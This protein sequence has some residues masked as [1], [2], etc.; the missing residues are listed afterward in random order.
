[1]I[2]VDTDVILDVML[3]RVPHVEASG[4]LLSL[5]EHRGH[6]AFVA[7]HTLS[8]IYYLVAPSRGGEGVREFLAELTRFVVV[9]PADGDALRFAAAL[10]MT[11]FE[12]ALQVGAARGCGA[13]VIATRNVRDYRGSPI[14]ART[15]RDLLEELG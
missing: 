4:A 3:D 13:E 10:P 6:R 15:P 7:W 11:D 1:M 2:L 8:N 14:P 9:A 5:L 12:D